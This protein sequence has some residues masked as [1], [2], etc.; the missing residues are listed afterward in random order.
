MDS[1]WCADYDDDEYGETPW[2]DEAGDSKALVKL[3]GAPFQ[4]F[5]KHR[6]K[7][8]DE[9]M[10]YIYPG[11]IQYFGPTEVCDQPT[12]TLQLEKGL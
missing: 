12:K 4:F 11:P 10:S 8:A 1:R 9:N 5:A 2:T 6:Q 3:D 7:W